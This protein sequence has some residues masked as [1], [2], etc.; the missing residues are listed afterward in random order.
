MT[1]KTATVKNK[2]GIHV[3]PTGVIIHSL[4]GVNADVTVKGKGMETDLRDH[5][6]LLAMGLC[7]GDRVE[8]MVNGEG[9]EQLC[10]ALVELF[11]KEFDFP[12]RH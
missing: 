9:E 10:D 11:E 12:P 2:M 1:K 4:N 7:Q 6:G 3:R 5:M 8:I